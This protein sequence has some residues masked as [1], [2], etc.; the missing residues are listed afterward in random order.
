MIP[1]SWRLWAWGL[2]SL[3]RVCTCDKREMSRSLCMYVCVNC[4]VVSNSLWP[5]GLQPTRLLCHG[6]LQA[7][8]PEW[9]AIPFSRESSQSRDWTWDSCI[10]GRFFTIWVTW[11]AQEQGILYIKDVLVLSLWLNQEN[12]KNRPDDFSPRDSV[13]SSV[14]RIY[15]LKLGGTCPMLWETLESKILPNQ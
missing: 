2:L 14:T 6:V 10:A 4:S 7:R 8:I 12:G 3:L 5:H 1:A 11:E 15:H 9:V 13:S